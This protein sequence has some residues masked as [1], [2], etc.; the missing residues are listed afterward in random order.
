MVYQ[1]QKKDADGAVMR[2]L[3]SD[4]IGSDDADGHP[5]IAMDE[6][7]VHIG[8]ELVCYEAQPV[9][10]T[11]D[12]DVFTGDV[13]ARLNGKKDI[14]L[15]IEWD[16]VEEGSDK[17]AQGHVT[18]YDSETLLDFLSET[19]SVKDLEAGDTIQFL[20]DYYDANGKL[21]DTRPAGGKIRITKQNR[22]VVEDAPLGDCDI[23]FGGVL[24]DVYQ[25]VMTTEQIEVY[26][27]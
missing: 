8:G 22:L 20:F 25:R 16:P 17:P 23:S 13:K 10:E 12:G 5:M 24:T 3:G 9:R 11:D 1:K 14:T 7:W 27:E 6:N 26:M 19:K 4:H 21:V 18:G 15:K 2:Y